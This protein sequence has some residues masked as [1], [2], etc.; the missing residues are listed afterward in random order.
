MHAGAIQKKALYVAWAGGVCQ[1]QCVGIPLLLAQCLGLPEGV[2][3][4]LDALP[5][6]QLAES[7]VVEPMSPSDWEV[8]ELNAAHIEAQMMEQACGVLIV[9]RGVI[10]HIPAGS[11]HSC[12]MHV[13]L[14]CVFV[15][16]SGWNELLSSP[17]ALWQGN[18]HWYALRYSW[19][20][21][22]GSCWPCG[23]F[24]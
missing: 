11:L 20:V 23:C 1:P 19:H 12:P 6:V 24:C 8:V 17:A 4:L 7:A 18:M 14:L 22:L 5:G 13:G 9:C 15:C 21:T 16:I 10:S 2:F 3:V